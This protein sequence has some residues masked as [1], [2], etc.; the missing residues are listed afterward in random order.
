MIFRNYLSLSSIV[1]VVLAAPPL[2]DQTQAGTTERP[3]GTSFGVPGSSSKFD[4][5]VIGGGTAGLTVAERLSEDPT[6]SVAVIEAGGFYELTDGN[7]SQIPAF[8]AKNFN[9]TPTAE[10]IQPLIDWAYITEPQL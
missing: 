3:V 8:Y 5:V 7:V 4:Y 6:V 9:Q 2:L 10:T 1:S